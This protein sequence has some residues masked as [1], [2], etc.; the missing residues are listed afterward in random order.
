MCEAVLENVEREYPNQVVHLAH[1]AAELRPPRERHPV[2]YGCFDW[3][4]AVHSHWA[5]LRLWRHANLRARI[6]AVMKARV[7]PE[8]I[9]AEVAYLGPR[10]RFELPYGLAWLLC[11]C[12]EASRCGEIGAAIRLQLGPL[13]QLS[14]IH[15]S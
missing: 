1:G 8:A 13:E 4:S 10:A 3:H 2:F 6:E 12:G 11:L 5:L 14:L 7:T 9:A 15:I